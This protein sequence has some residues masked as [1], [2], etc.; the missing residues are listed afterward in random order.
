MAIRVL[1]AAVAVALLGPVGAIATAHA[2]TNDA[3]FLSM[4]KSEGITNQ[5]AP[6]RAIEAGHAVCQEFE[7]GK[8]AADIANEVLNGSDMPAYHCGFFVGAAVRA[9]CPQYRSKASGI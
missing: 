6:S 9:Y 7:S 1:V 2:D 8:S 4:L 5:V 3:N